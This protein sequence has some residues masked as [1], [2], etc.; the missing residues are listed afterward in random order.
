MAHCGVINLSK[1][2]LYGFLE[3]AT[4][5]CNTNTVSYQRLVWHYGKLR[6]GS[7]FIFLGK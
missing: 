6:S 5:A 1:F 4:C 3:Y 2:N 7:S